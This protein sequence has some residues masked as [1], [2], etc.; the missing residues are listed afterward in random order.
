[1]QIPA[2]VGHI[3]DGFEL[4]FGGGLAADNA[5]RVESGVGQPADGAGVAVDAHRIG[6]ADADAV[7]QAE[8][9]AVCRGGAGDVAVTFH[10]DGVAQCILCAGAAVAKL[11]AFGDGGCVGRNIAGV[12][13]DILV[14][15]IQLAACYRIG[16]AGRNRAIG[17]IG[18][19]IATHIQPVCTAAQHGAVA[20]ITQLHAGE[21]RRV[22]GGDADG[23]V[24]LGD[25]NVFAGINGY[26]VARVDFLRFA[27]AHAAARS[28]GGQFPAAIG[29]AV[30]AVEC[31]LH[32][33]VGVAAHFQP[34]GHAVGGCV[35]AGRAAQR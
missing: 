28:G 33:A 2:G 8:L 19:F 34:G 27:A 10:V 4:V 13:C 11:D 16:A 3:A 6:A 7:A 21:F 9:Y 32:A 35:I 20:G 22:A 29:H 25:G 31:I 12:G 18:H 24:V 26:R 23:A 17:K 30:D 14:G 1:M 15:G 5:I